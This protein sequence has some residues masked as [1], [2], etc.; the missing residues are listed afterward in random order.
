MKKL[1]CLL[2]VSFLFLCTATVAFA[3]TPSPSYSHIPPSRSTVDTNQDLGYFTQS[4]LI[5]TMAAIGC[6]LTGTDPVNPN[7]PCLGADGKGSIVLNTE[8]QGAIGFVTNMMAMTFDIPAHTGEYV[9]YATSGFGIAKSANAQGLGF[10]SISPLLS[11][12]IAFRNVIYILFVVIFMLIGF[13]IM[14]RYKVDGKTVMAIQTQ[15]P[16]AIITLLLITFSFGIVGFLIDVMYLFMYLFYEI[17]AG[18]PGVNVAGLNPSNLQ[19]TTPF[20]AIGFLD[21]TRIVAHASEGIGDLI[22]NILQG[23]MVGSLLSSIFGVFANPVGGIGGFGTNAIV[24]GVISRLTGLGSG[25]AGSEGVSNVASTIAFLIVAIAL[26]AT[27]LRLW[28]LLLK[29]YLFILIDTVVAPIWIAGSLIPGSPLTA[30]S[31]FRHIFAYIAVFPVTLFM[32]LLGSVFIQQFA[33]RAG[34][35]FTPPFIGNAINPQYFSALIGLATIF[36]TTEVVN[37]VK[38]TLKAPTVKY[39]QAIGQALGVGIPMVT[40]PIRGVARGVRR[41]GVRTIRPIIRDRRTAAALAAAGRLPGG[42]AGP[43]P[44]GAG[45]PAPRAREVL[46]RLLG[47]MIR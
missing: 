11:T 21:G 44:P 20:G 41:E 43:L 1:F 29:A 31:W 9:A 37:M 15:I 33:D 35:F 38:D 13:A 27:L 45:G 22:A 4:I 23:T 46:W 39:Q 10:N 32:L 3:Q 17:I 34:E 5:E 16:K 25:G 36:M 26:L 42:A 24:G 40:A 6:Q 8:N 47:S 30:G 28:I 18:I 2:L 12:W 7:R 19:G 14:L